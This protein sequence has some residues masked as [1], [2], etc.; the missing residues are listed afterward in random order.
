MCIKNAM[1][2]SLN[3]DT[4]TALKEDFDS[5]LARTISNMETKGA[6]EATIT[7]KLSV[8]L[9]KA[10]LTFGD[11]MEQKETVKPTF[12]HDISS[13]MQVK[14]KKSGSIS[15][16]Y[17]LAWDPEENKYVMRAI[18]NGQ[19]T[20]FTLEEDD[21]K[22]EKIDVA[23][24]MIEEAEDYDLAFDTSKPFGWLRQFVGENL[25]VSEAMGN[26]TVR[27]EENKVVLSSASSED[28]PFHCDAEKLEPHVEHNVVCVGHGEENLVNIAVECKDC[29]AV[30]FSIDLD[31]SEHDENKESETADITTEENE[32][33]NE[34]TESELNENNTEENEYE[35]DTPE[36]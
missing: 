1:Q 8:S 34:T 3:G 5:I 21:E 35:Y 26:F 6:N 4:F 7:L 27:T 13:V 19:L 33:E 32:T 15:G 31:T 29:G 28:S 2:L 16:D 9:E 24:E 30:L 20:L 22:D 36:A 10:M 23:E 18:T 17:E 25:N 12:K 11:D 14:D